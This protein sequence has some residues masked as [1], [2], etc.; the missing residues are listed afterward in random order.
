MKR[1]VL[2]AVIILTSLSAVRGQDLPNPTANLQTLPAGSF[3]IAMDNTYQADGS[4]KFNLK[5][6]GLVV[7]LLNYGVKV[8]WVIKAGKTKDGIDFT[9]STASLVPVSNTVTSKITTSNGSTSATV[10]NASGLVVGMSVTSSSNGIQAGTTITAISGL[11]ITLSLPATANINNKNADFTSYTYPV[12][13]RSFRAA[14]F[15]IFAADTLGVRSLINMFY[16]SQGLTGSNRPN[17]YFTASAT[18]NVDIRYNLSGFIPKAA[19]LTDG[20]NEDIHRDYMIAAGITSQN[21]KEVAGVTLSDCYTFASEPHNNEEG[22]E[23]DATVASIKNFVQGGRNFLAQCAATRNYENNVN[24]H[25]HT[26]EGITDANQGIGTNVNYNASDLS[27]YQFEGSYNASSGGSLKNWF[28]NGSLNYPNAYVNATGVGS[29]SSVQAATYTKMV[30]GVGGL[31]FYLGNHDFS[32]NSE[33]GINGIRMYM[34]A[35]LTP[36]SLAGSDCDF[37]LLGLQLV[38]FNGNLNNNKV[39][40][41]WNVAHNENA[42]QFEVEESINGTQF[43]TAGLVLSSSNSGEEKYSFAVSMKA[44]KM[45]FRLKITEKSGATSYSK[46]LAFQSAVET[47][48][49]NTLK[50]LNNPAADKLTL[51]FQS[52]ANQSVMIQLVDMTGR[53]VMQQQVNSFQGHNITSLSLPSALNNGIYIVDLFDGVTHSTSRFVKQ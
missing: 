40:L 12:S 44:A 37:P 4:N 3:V 27:F 15:V 33:A 26:T 10:N 23:I 47:V 13:S 39:S 14:P 34:N 49:N 29:Y 50:V 42:Q 52:S 32:L 30:S 43:N 36:A 7:H 2:A 16:A 24:G 22:D 9:A 28:L 31:V 5:A 48:S 35:F 17:V 45:Y 1:S 41:N 38:N 21:Y 51:S 11:N 6:Y 46:I 8:K 20:G 53:R 25:F 19:I 18:A